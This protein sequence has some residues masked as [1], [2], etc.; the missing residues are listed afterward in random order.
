MSSFFISSYV[1]LLNVLAAALRVD[2]MQPVSRKFW[3]AIP[4]KAGD[5]TCRQK[6]RSWSRGPGCKRAVQCQEN[7]CRAVCII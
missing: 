5:S 4:A 1:S 6:P 7:L 3:L 2:T